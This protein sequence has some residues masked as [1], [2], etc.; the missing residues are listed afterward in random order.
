MRI[1]LLTVAYRTD[2]SID[3]PIRVSVEFIVPVSAKE[4]SEVIAEIQKSIALRLCHPDGI[5]FVKSSNGERCF[6][7]GTKNTDEKKTN[8]VNCGAPL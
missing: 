8:C 1:S 7:C 6:H 2:V 3:N 5:E 4:K